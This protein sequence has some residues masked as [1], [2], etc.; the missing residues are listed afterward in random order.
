[1]KSIKKG[2]R[3]SKNCIFEEDQMK[4]R[5]CKSPCYNMRKPE[6]GFKS[7]NFKQKWQR[8]TILFKFLQT[9][10]KVTFDILFV[11]SC[12]FTL[13]VSC[14]LGLT[15]VKCFASWVCQLKSNLIM[16]S[17]KNQGP[18]FSGRLSVQSVSCVNE[19]VP[20]TTSAAVVSSST[21]FRQ[22]D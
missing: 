20:L 16:P 7:R 10:K 6:G 1:M 18:V 4:M 2:G 3:L 5:V 15:P 21:R 8:Q 11:M 17:S 13:C 19:Y 12:I 9:D 14:V 22:T